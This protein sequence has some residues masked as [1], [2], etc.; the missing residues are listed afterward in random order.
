MAIDAASGAVRWATAVPGDPLGGVAVV[1]DLLLTALL[2]GT[3]LA[4]SRATGEIVHQFAA[5]GGINGWMSIV[6]DTIY[7]PVGQASPPQIVAYGIPGQ[8]G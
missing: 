5:P 1:N 7:L 4:L 2:D 8:A 6:G 3:V